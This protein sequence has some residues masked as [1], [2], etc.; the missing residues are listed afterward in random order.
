MSQPQYN[1]SDEFI[2]QVAKLLQMALLTGTSIGDNL[3]L[4]QLTPNDDG[5][6]TLTEEYKK[7]FETSIEKM[8]VEAEDIKEQMRS[9]IAQA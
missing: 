6:L 4:V 5:K 2:A 1:L 9:T 8:L 7:N 3:R